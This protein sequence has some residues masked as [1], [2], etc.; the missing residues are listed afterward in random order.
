MEF[1]IK[2]RW[3]GTI[4]FTA[5]LDARYENDPH[6]IQLGAA[7][8][9][10]VKAGANLAD[11]DLAG[12]NLVG[13]YLADA[14]LAGADLAGAKWRHGIVLKRTPIQLYNLDNGWRVTILDEHMEIGCELHSFDEWAA[15][16]DKEIAAMDGRRALNFWRR[17]KPSLMALCEARKETA[18]KQAPE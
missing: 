10:A 12:A 4:I 1:E 9:A 15:F 17:W 6:S 13:A 7:I 16:T 3:T 14:N 18:T 11:A 8:R 5:D 2:N